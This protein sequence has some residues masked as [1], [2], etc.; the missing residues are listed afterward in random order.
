M[1]QKQEYI[2]GSRLN[3]LMTARGL[4]PAEIAKIT[5]IGRQRIYDYISG[6]S[7][8]RAR[9]IKQIALGLHVSADWL[10]GIID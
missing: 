1:G 2:F 8:P 9:A 10:L 6:V 5:G 7:E 3:T 4:Y